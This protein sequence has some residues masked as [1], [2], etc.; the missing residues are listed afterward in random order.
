LSTTDGEPLV[1]KLPLILEGEKRIGVPDAGLAD[2]LSGGIERPGAAG[3][4][5]SFNR[6]NEFVH[7]L[8]LMPTQCP[9]AAEPACCGRM[10]TRVAARANEKQQQEPR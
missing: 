4:R 10:G 6:M 1:A 3:P 8:F 2:L 7:E 5:G 9:S